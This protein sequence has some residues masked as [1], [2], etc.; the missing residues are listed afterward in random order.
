[1]IRLYTHISPVPQVLHTRHERK[2]SYWHCFIL[3]SCR[4]STLWLQTVEIH[5]SIYLD[6]NYIYVLKIS[7]F[8][9]FSGVQFWRTSSYLGDIMYTRN[10]VSPSFTLT[11]A[12]LYACHSSWCQYYMYRFVYNRSTER[13][14]G[15]T[16]VHIE[17]VCGSKPWSRQDYLLALYLCNRYFLL[18]FFS[19]P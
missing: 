14:S 18:S 11:C 4:C 17:N 5:I 9:N 6:L 13:C 7:D 12:I 19:F 3:S 15:S 10:F 2:N 8:V 1:M 16:R